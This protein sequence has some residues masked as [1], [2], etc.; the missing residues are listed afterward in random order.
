MKKRPLILILLIAFALSLTGALSGCSALSGTSGVQDPYAAIKE[1]Y[2]TQEFTITF[3]SENLSEP[4]DE[5]TYTAYNMPTLPTPKRVGYVFD[6]WYFDQNYTTVYYENVLYLYMC[7]VTLYAKWV[8]EEL[9]QD[10]VYNVDVSLAVTDG[11]VQKNSL[12]DKYGNSP[13]YFLS[14]VDTD[15]MQVEKIGDQ[16]LF[17]FPYQI[18]TLTSFGSA[19]MYNVAVNSTLMGSSV[20]IAE[21]VMAQSETDRTLYFDISA[22]DLEDTIYLTVTAYKW[23]AEVEEGENIDNTRI[24]FTLEVTITQFYGLTTS[25]AD[26]DIQLEDGY[27]SLKTY[28]DAD[29]M[30][31][32]DPVYSYL[33]AEDGHY[34]LIKPFTPY[35]GYVGEQFSTDYYYNMD[36]AMMPAQYY[37]CVDENGAKS[38][39]RAMEIEYHA[40]TGRYYYIYDLGTNVKQNIVF[41]Y[42]IGGPMQIL[43]RMGSAEMTLDVSYDAMIKV[44]DTGYTPLSGDAYCYADSFSAIVSDELSMSEYE[45]INNYGTSIDFINFYYSALS[46]DSEEKTMYSHRITISPVGDTTNGIATFGMDVS[47]YGYDAAAGNLYANLFTDGSLK[48]TAYWGNE[49]V[50]SGNSYSAGDTI[51]LEEI[52]YEKVAHDGDFSDVTITA[53][54]MSGDTVDYAAEYDLNGAVRFTFTGQSIAVV[55]TFNEYDEDGNATGVNTAVVELRNYYAPTVFFDDDFIYDATQTERDGNIL[56]LYADTQYTSGTNVRYPDLNY[57]WFSSEG[58]FI[59]QYSLVNEGESIHPIYVNTYYADEWDNYYYADLTAASDGTYF[60]MSHDHVVIVYELHNCYGER[61]YVHIHFTVRDAVTEQTYAILKNGESIASGTVSYTAGVA[62]TV[63]YAESVTSFLAAM[64]DLET[65]L[66]DSYVFQLG[67]TQTSMNLQSATVYTPATVVTLT[68]DIAVSVR[69]LLND[70]DYA[71]VSLTY[72]DGTNSYTIR[73]A[74]NMYLEGMTEYEALSYDTIFTGREYTLYNPVVRDGKGLVLSSGS[75]FSVVYSGSGSGSYT[76]TNYG[77]SYAIQFSSVGQYTINYRVNFSYLGSGERV[78]NRDGNRYYSNYILVSQ[79]VAVESSSSTVTVT[80]VTDDEHPFADGTTERT[81]TYSLTEIIYLLSG[82]SFLTS[83][84]GH[85]LY[86]WGISP[87]YNITDSSRLSNPGAAINDFIGTFNSNDVTLYAVWDEKTTVSLS[88]ITVSGGEGTVYRE[89][90][91][92]VTYSATN[93]RYEI[94]VAPYLTYAQNYMPSGYVLLGFTGGI[95]GDE[96]VSYDSWSAYTNRYVYE[97]GYYEI[98]AVYAR[99]HTV[100]YDTGYRTYSDTYYGNESVVEGGTVGEAK[101]VM[102]YEGYTFA[103]WCVQTAE[104]IY[105]TSDIVDMASYEIIEDTTFVAL[106][107]NA[108]GELVW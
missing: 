102:P 73:Y 7:D 29:M 87:N 88:L 4:I 63:E 25:F 51:D 41:V 62:E 30:S 18:H 13:D 89:N 60:R 52:F 78:F 20:S 86:G 108:E 84:D 96:L 2:G 27:Y 3:N 9:V 35:T 15:G 6:G 67:D 14:D 99:V 1:A 106:Y 36:T 43:F 85:T 48:E 11:S 46:A 94:A 12:A 83:E 90:L 61:Y 95:F 75:S 104:E 28:F 66:G 19:E 59:D 76:L 70:A 16:I 77:D 31:S 50:R 69:S 53:Y 92:T 97:P 45:Y 91:R 98:Y 79:T 64:T 81:E 100:R 82:D 56:H 42:V 72:S 80:Y 39:Y 107:Y 105:T 47:V 103:G 10:G 24:S 8:K 33:Y 37:Y 22:I 74:Y 21:S 17:K 57:L 38:E 44:S 93:G 40:D 68:E 5:M 26:P 58:N 101:A 65:V 71:I 49:E 23:D 34:K 32:Y 55:Y 54:L